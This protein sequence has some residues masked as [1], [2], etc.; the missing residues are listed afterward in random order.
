MNPIPFSPEPSDAEV[1]STRGPLILEFGT[2]WCGHCQAAQPLIAAA[3]Q[4]HPDIRHLRIEDGKGRP[5]GRAF[6]VKLWPTLVFLRDGQEIARVV[7]PRDRDEIEVAVERM[8]P[9]EKGG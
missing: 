1:R 5:L 2:D 4:Q 6:R 7:R 9:S 3:L 8:S